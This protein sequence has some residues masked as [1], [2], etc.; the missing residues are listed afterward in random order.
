MKNLSQIL[1][2]IFILLLSCDALD[3]VVSSVE[4][5]ETELDNSFYIEEGWSSMNSSNYMDAINFFEYL[6]SAINSSSQEGEDF[7]DNDKKLLVQANH[8]LA[9]A[10]LLLSTT[11]LSDNKKDDRDE[12]Y[13]L[14]FKAQDI[15][16]ENE[17]LSFEDMSQ[18]QCDIYAGKILYSDY[19]IYYYQNLLSNGGDIQGDEQ[20]QRDYFSQGELSG[21]DENQNGHI[22][23]GIYQLI[24]IM[25]QDCAEYSAQDYSFDHNIMFNFNDLKLIL[26]KDYIRREEYVNARDNIDDMIQSMESTSITFQLNNQSLSLDQPKKVVGDFDNKTID[27][28]DVY[29]LEIVDD[30]YYFVNIDVNQFMPC[31]FDDSFDDSNSDHVSALRDELYE[32]INGF[33][34]FNSNTAKTFKYRFVD[35]DY[36]ADIISNQESSLPSSCSSSDS[37][38]T[39]Q[40]PYNSYDDIILEPTCFN[41][42]SSNC[43]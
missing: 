23:L 39:I 29:D 36:D 32:C 34:Y 35:G 9:W 43:N 16:D 41:S 22:E 19:M 14:F 6:I 42:C 40:I 3:E 7:S 25:Q 21:L 8:G 1:Y 4:E 33:D 31:N 10:K 18:V 27:V 11:S 38:R 26:V 2:F 20:Q 37:Y 24:S 5:G 30:G 13:E 12:S 15:I 28:N 17:N